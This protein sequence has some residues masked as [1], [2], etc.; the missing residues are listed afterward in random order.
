[1]KINYRDLGRVANAQES[2]S[3]AMT[4]GTDGKWYLVILSSG[5]VVSTN[6]HTAESTFCPFPDGYVDYPFGS[7]GA[8]TGKI[9]FGAGRMFYEFDPVLN[10]YTFSASL[11]DREGVCEA[12]APFEAADGG[13]WFGAYPVTRLRRYDPKTHT[14]TDHGIMGVDQAYLS[15]VAQDSSG[16]IYGGLG[17]TCPTIAAYCPETGEHRILATSHSIGDCAEVRVSFLGEVYGTLT[18][19]SSGAPYNPKLEWHR[20]ENGTWGEQVTEPFET[21]YTFAH[22]NA[23]HCPFQEHPQILEHD[24]VE[25]RLVYRH[26]DTGETAT[27][28]LAYDV[29]GAELSPIAAGPDGK[30]YGTTNHPIQ[31]FTYNPKTDTLTNFGRKPFARHISG[32]GN[33]C[34]YASQGDILAGAAYCGGFV[35]RIDTKESICRETDDVNPHCEG[36]FQEVL[37][38]RS[39]A[40]LADG[41]TMLFGGFNIYGKAGGGMICYDSQSRECHLIPNEKLLPD[42]SILAILPLSETTLLCG[43]SIEVPGGGTP[44]V[45]EAELFLYDLETRQVLTH[46]TPIPGARELAHLAQDGQ[47]RIHGISDSGILFTLDATGKTLLATQD[48]SPFGTPVRDGMKTASD[49]SVYGLLTGGIYRIRPGADAAEFLPQPPC[50][51]TCG[52]ALIDGRIYFGSNSHL[53]SVGPL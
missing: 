30:V 41:R 32:W 9:Y 27:V 38:P 3:C 53:F 2:R 13:I 24:L 45:K 16:W 46:W 43:T 8:K 20:L 14:I 12:W 21:L 28:N 26:P 51:I 10:R 47:G 6:L 40:A 49:G 5:F 33:I 37:R 23:I 1:M 34:A 31:I 7:I 25:H 29:A 50:P 19:S 35:V 36:A 11:G 44:A 48:L 15:S 22:F 42:H 39:A 18:G 4:K 52:M 17:T